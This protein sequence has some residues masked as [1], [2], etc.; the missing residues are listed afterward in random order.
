MKATIVF[1]GS[2][3][4]ALPPTGV[5]IS[6]VTTL[7]AYCAISSARLVLVAPPGAWLEGLPEIEVVTADV[8]RSRRHFLLPRLLKS[9]AATLLHS[10]VAAL[11]LRTPCPCIATIHDLPWRARVP[12]AENGVSLRHRLALHLALARAR[13]VLV[14]SLATAAD[15]DNLPKLRV[16]PHGIT[17][18]QTAAAASAL[19]GPFLAIGDD[20]PR[21]NLDRL[22]AAHTMA[23]EMDQEL[24]DL[25]VIGPL[26]GYVDETEKVRLLRTCRALVH[27]AL[28]EGFG[29]PVLEAM[30][31]GVP[32]LASSQ[33][34][35]VELAGEAALV[36]DPLDTAAIA[37]G[38]VLVH[39]D[40]ALRLR[41]ASA[42][43]QRAS[44]FTP[45]R[46]AELWSLAHAEAMAP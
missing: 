42:G 12:L 32:V 23:R 18:P 11:P 27:V 19:R 14:P 21:K 5:A 24:P 39:R 33:R 8:R 16:V 30:A 44:A 43:R 3:L 37:A 10:P 15:L 7:R 1:D 9:L 26:G 31:H 41:L 17:T 35:L 6:F 40:E 45:A 13:I 29:L 20:R 38:L 4:G 2:V 22:R 36:V 46:S 25:R 28:H 34:A